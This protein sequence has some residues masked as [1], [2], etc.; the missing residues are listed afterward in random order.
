M[1]QVPLTQGYFAM[2]DDEDFGKVAGYPCYYQKGAFTE[3]AVC[4]LG[5][6]KTIGM[7]RL[8]TNAPEGMVVDHID[9]NGLNNQKL[10]LRLVTTKENLNNR[11]DRSLLG[12]GKCKYLFNVVESNDSISV[13]CRATETECPKGYLKCHVSATCWKV[14]ICQ[15]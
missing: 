6:Q 7:H 8:I 11:H 12:V 10:N 9:G 3:Y 14:A 15:N 5:E 2:V 4:Y 1:K 13:E